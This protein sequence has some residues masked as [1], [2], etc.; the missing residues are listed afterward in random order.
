[1]RIK[2]Y[3]RHILLFCALPITIGLGSH[4]WAEVKIEPK[5]QVQ[6]VYTDNVELTG[7]NTQSDLIFVGS[8]GLFIDIDRNRARGSIDYNLSGFF[9]THD[10]SRSEIRHRLNGFVEGDIVRDLFSVRVNGSVGQQFADISGP[11]SANTGNFT[12]NRRTVQGYSV[13]PR[14]YR[15]FGSFGQ[16]QI[17][18]TYGY[19]RFENDNDNPNAV[20]LFDSNRHRAGASFDSGSRFTRL[21]WGLSGF[22]DRVKRGNGNEFEAIESKLALGYALGRKIRIVSDLGYE[23][24]QDDTLGRDED[25]FIWNAGINVT[26]SRRSEFEF[27]AGERF[28][29]LVFSGNARY[30]I[31]SR[32]T[33]SGSYSEDIQVFGRGNID[34]ISLIEAI[35]RG[36]P[37]DENGVPITVGAPGFELTNFAFR[38]KRASLSLQR[39][40]RLFSTTLTGFWERRRFDAEPD[41]RISFGGTASLGY[42]IDSRQ[43]ANFSGTYRNSDLTNGLNNKFFSLSSS[44]NIK[45]TEVLT[46]SARYVYSRRVGASGINLN[47]N[48]VL[49]T[50]G[51]TF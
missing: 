10:T 51:A 29:D 25:G 43:S 32:H 26:P 5:V 1:M 13:T 35:L 50:I 21:S 41:A 15:E 14:L 30:R 42:T 47:E 28:G 7:T 34:R 37:V 19:S 16:G 20:S 27:R 46:G 45:L 22:Y 36:I 4:S 44:Y 18:Y 6:A 23:D 17:T 38:Q 8:P 40:S 12:D 48:A 49:L 24:F 2:N 31:D 9:S 39:S 11:I 33:I 3:K